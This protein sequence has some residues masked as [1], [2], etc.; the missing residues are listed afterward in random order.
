MLSFKSVKVQFNFIYLL[1]H[2][3]N[4]DTGSVVSQL[5]FF[6]IIIF[7]GWLFSRSQCHSRYIKEKP[8]SSKA[9]HFYKPITFFPKY[10]SLLCPYAKY[11]KGM[12]MYWHTVLWNYYYKQILWFEARCPSNNKNPYWSAFVYNKSRKNHHIHAWKSVFV[13]FA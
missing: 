13:N 7:N 5:L 10:S 6:L 3:H 2:F 4:W 1:P 8:L 11:S 9:N 12:S